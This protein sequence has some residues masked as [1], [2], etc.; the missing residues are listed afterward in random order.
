MEWTAAARAG[1]QRSSRAG[2][3]AVL[4]LAVASGC[5]TTG[6]PSLLANDP[7]IERPTASAT[8]DVLVAE[9]AS[10]EGRLD[11]ARDAYRR[12]AA[13]DPTSSYLQ[14]RLATLAAQNDEF[15]TAVR[16]AER[17][18]ELDPESERARLFLGR[19]HRA[20]RDVPAAEKVLRNG[21]EGEPTS[22]AAAMMMAQFY[23]EQGR[24]ESALAMAQQALAYE[25]DEIRA[26]V[27]LARCYEVLG[28]HAEAEASLRA[29]LRQY[30]GE[31]NIYAQL[32]RQRRVAGDSLGEIEIYREILEHHPGHFG[33]LTDLGEAL[34]AAGDKEGARAVYEEL[35]ERYPDNLSSVVRLAGLEADA[36]ESEAAAD[37]IDAILG[38]N[39]ERAEL[40]LALGQLRRELGQADAAIEA[41]ERVPADHPRF[42]DARL[43]LATIHEER[44]DFVAALREVETLHPLFPSR[45]L[46]FHL[47]G[48]RSRTG[49]LDGAVELLE[50]MLVE[51]PG[52][53]EVLYQLG[54]TY[55][56]AKRHEDAMRFVEQAI[57]QDGD[58]AQAL[59]YLGYTLAERGERLDEAEALISRAIAL[60]PADGYIRDSLGWVYYQRALA[61]GADDER[62]SGLLEEALEHLI[63]AANLTG[64]DPVVSEHIGDVYRLLG[65]PARA[66]EFYL[67][68]VSL[69]PRADEQPDLDSKIDAL[70]GHQGV[71]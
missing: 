49:D 67:E 4:G 58:N 43:Q 13:K 26:H 33:T 20:R 23:L 18:L 52:D 27:V 63:A 5:A 46:E 44:Q 62:T 35:V 8:Y 30:P 47:A 37:R 55:G 12:A 10:R 31:L 16:L 54:V 42:F 68:A 50:S 11:E 51:T 64:G 24:A 48:L 66:L 14:L 41:F 40:A 21:P 17:A 59:N 65:D 53:A 32:L 57:E 22:F 3:I 9:L 1:S 6:A 45:P 38:S 61:L 29:V 36:G 56:L 69:E 34:R 15:P 28:R 19:L 7:P 71:R 70:R 39:P 2:L 25:P 60:Q